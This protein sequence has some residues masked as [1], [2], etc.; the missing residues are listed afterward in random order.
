MPKVPTYDALQV[1]P[2]PQPNV[3]FRAPDQPDVVGRQSAQM[4]EG[5]MRLGGAVGRIAAD[6]E[7]QANKARIADAVN[8]IESFAMDAEIEGRKLKGKNA[9]ERPDGLP[10]PDEFGNK[11]SERVRQVNE[12]LGNETQKRAFSQYANRIGLRLRGS[13]AGHMVEEQGRFADETDAQSINNA[14]KKGTLFWGD[15]G[16]R[17]EAMQ[18]I[19]DAINRAAERKGWDEETKQSKLRDA[20]SPMHAGIIDGLIK[21]NRAGDARAYFEGVKDQMTPQSTSQLSGI[22]KEADDAQ[23]ADAG[24]ET[25]W[26]S[27]GPKGLNDPV[28]I[29]DMEKMAREMFKDAPD[30]AKR[31]IDGLRQRAQAWNA[32]Q[33]ENKASNVNAVF[34]LID[35]KVPIAQVQ[36][37][38]AWLA[39][40]EKSRREIMKSVD[41]EEYQREAR[42]AARAARA[43]ADAQRGLAE[44][45]RQ[46]RMLLLTKPDA[47]LRYSDPAVLASISSRQQVEALRTE[48][49]LEAT[50]HLL[51]RWDSLQ[52]ADGKWKAQ[53]DQDLFNKVADEMG[54][55]PFATQ[56]T[57]TQREDLGILKYRVERLIDIAQQ[58]KKGVLTPAETEELIRGEISRKVTVDRWGPDEEVP[59]IALRER[60]MANVIIPAQERAKIKEALAQKYKEDPTNPRHAPTKENMVRLYVMNRSKAGAF[61]DVK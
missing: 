27:G 15:V 58:A 45:Q 22:V 30:L 46:D 26:A 52:K 3:Q 37:S 48:F 13:L 5:L 42:A 11:F 8:Q 17:R 16:A 9:L 40:D 12:S 14:I 57:Q 51:S 4:G 50:Q 20:M 24:A 33:S 38:D 36:K 39:L 18:G 54:F 49:G 55:K 28:N 61:F 43:A 44:L 31:A 29:F 35:Q 1:E 21:A 25:V 32:Q 23:K 10:L 19:T 56:K 60:D 59:I 2:S 7:E 41:A 34:G 6:L 47:Y 53:I